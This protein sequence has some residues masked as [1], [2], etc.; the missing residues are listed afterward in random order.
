M[1]AVRDKDVT[2]MKTWRQQLEPVRRLFSQLFAMTSPILLAVFAGLVFLL[3]GQTL[4]IYRAIHQA[5]A[6]KCGT[7]TSQKCAP[8]LTEV[9]LIIA[10][11]A[12]LSLSIWLLARRLA[13]VQEVHQAHRETDDAEAVSCLFARGAHRSWLALWG[14]RLL[15]G[16]VP[17]MAAI[18]VW[19]AH[20][21]VSHHDDLRGAMVS[22]FTTQ[23]ERVGN[24][25]PIAGLLAKR[26]AEKI[27][28]GFRPVWFLVT[29]LVLTVVLVL[30]AAAADRPI[31]SRRI[32]DLG[33]LTP[34]VTFAG[35]ALL[36]AGMVALTLLHPVS[37]PQ[38]VGP[39]FIISAFFTLTAMALFHLSIFSKATGVPV[40]TILVLLAIGLSIADWNDNH[41]IRSIAPEKGTRTA[42]PTIDDAFR[43][44]FSSRKDHD[45]FKSAGEPYPIFVV[46]AQGGGVYAAKHA[47]SFL[48]EVQ[49]LCPGFAHHLFAI[50]GVSGGSVGA[51]IFGAM[52]RDYDWTKS[53]VAGLQNC[54]ADLEGAQDKKRNTHFTDGV[55]VVF[56]R[57]LWAPLAAG[58]LFPDFTQRFLPLSIDD[59]DR[60]RW[61]EYAV[62]DAFQQML[63]EN[64]WLAA[65]KKSERALEK[66]FLDYW[67][68]EQY[69]DTPALI[70]NTTEVASGERLVI[71]PFTFA[72]AGLDVLPVFDCN[73]YGS[74]R[75]SPVLSAAAGVSARFPWITPA[76]YFHRAV[77][78]PK[79]NEDDTV[80]VRLVDGGYFENSGVATALDLIR[81]IV[82]AVGEKEDA[83]R[84]EINLL[85]FTSAGFDKRH[86]TALGELID[87]VRT[88]LATQNA[89]AGITV[90]ESIVALDGMST[91][92]S[93]V[94][95]NVIKLELGGNGYPLPLGWRLSE[96][97]RHLITHAN[98]NERHCDMDFTD[99]DRI[100]TDISSSCAKKLVYQRLK[101]PLRRG[102]AGGGGSVGG[103]SGAGDPAQ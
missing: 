12:I 10:G 44:W 39:F 55:T 15:A 79:P 89:R 83:P 53:G 31:V 65:G 77:V 22:A 92:K 67:N 97:T 17:L 60:A 46:A 64:K 84:V 34:F 29:L 62:E 30:V 98:G 94:H 11:I 80:K 78:D 25:P 73:R 82:A 41:S 32:V 18:G 47:A 14:P 86:P 100:D 2:A 48:A 1:M 61:L 90:E 4:E 50:S 45:D 7:L 75:I 96:V 95:A 5:F 8:V 9:G 85:V 71:A 33:S 63:R 36:I 102:A 59:W 28:T 69:P 76:A 54:I 23:Y 56:Q 40:L 16:V 13:S 49:D 74:Q 20:I 99:L 72:G 38:G 26:D 24:T 19:S 52:T 37:F 43:R 51:A 103:G 88:L 70:F 27:V 101:L 35:V 91:S 81:G 66:A 57:D 68:P 6:V 93:K 42:T 87:P 58:L 21:D 3:P